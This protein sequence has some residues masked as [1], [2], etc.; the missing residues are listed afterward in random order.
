MPPDLPPPPTDPPGYYPIF[1]PRIAPRA[2]SRHHAR[3]SPRLPLPTT[4][5]PPAERREAALRSALDV[6]NQLAIDEHEAA[7]SNRGKP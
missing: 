4:L 2:T 5:S 1:R 3:L 7:S 6:M